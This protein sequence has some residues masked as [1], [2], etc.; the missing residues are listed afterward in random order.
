MT[1]TQKPRL[2]AYARTY[3]DMKPDAFGKWYAVGDVDALLAAEV[4]EIERLKL[5]LG[6]AKLAAEQYAE[7]VG[8]C[9]SALDEANGRTEVQR[10]LLR[11]TVALMFKTEYSKADRWNQ[12]VRDYL[13]L[14]AIKEVQG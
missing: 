3:D 5:D 10:K 8:H 12:E 13:A 11:E 6:L 9:E 14:P 1:D 7:R 2:Q 4:A